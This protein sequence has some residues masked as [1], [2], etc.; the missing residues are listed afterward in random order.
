MRKFASFG[1]LCAI[2][3]LLCSCSIA[4]EPSFP[5]DEDQTPIITGENPLPEDTYFLIAPETDSPVGEGKN[6]TDTGEIPWPED[7]YFLLTRADIIYYAEPDV[8]SESLGARG[9]LGYEL[10]VAEKT[11]NGKKWYKVLV[12][13]AGR[14]WIESEKVIFIETAEE[15]I[16]KN[17]LFIE[18]TSINELI[19]TFGTYQAFEVAFSAGNGDTTISLKWPDLAIVLVA[20]NVSFAG[21]YDE[22]YSY[23]GRAVLTDAD[24]ALLFSVQAIVSTKTSLRGGIEIGDHISSVEELVWLV[25]GGKNRPAIKTGDFYLDDYYLR[26]EYLE[27]QA[28][29]AFT[30]YNSVTLPVDS[31]STYQCTTYYFKNNKLVAFAQER[32]PNVP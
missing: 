27:F 24:K 10:A 23:G 22:S 28:D 15:N 17:G 9:G 25:F 8:S 11:V 12:N 13:E 19:S 7:T 31:L 20:N 18:E 6:P 3:I 14:F 30:A 5:A 21:S 16:A 26:S 29:E 4:P 1:L 2:G 32:N